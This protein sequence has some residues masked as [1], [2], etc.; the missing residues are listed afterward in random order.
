MYH[1][2]KLQEYRTAH[3]YGQ[4]NLLDEQTDVW[5]SSA[6]KSV[7]TSRTNSSGAIEREARNG[8]MRHYSF[9]TAVPG[10]F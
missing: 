2:Q 6:T 9:A 3:L 7:G 8:K 5:G 10:A 4:G 1:K